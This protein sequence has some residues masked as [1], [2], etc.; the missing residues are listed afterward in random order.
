MHGE[1]KHGEPLTKY[2]KPGKVTKPGNLIRSLAVHVKGPSELVS[3]QNLGVVLRD[4]KKIEGTMPEFLRSYGK[5]TAEQVLSEGKLIVAKG[6]A[7]AGTGLIRI[8][9]GEIPPIRGCVDVANV[10]I[11]VGRLLGMQAK[12]VRVYN[13]SFAMLKGEEI[14]LFDISGTGFPKVLGKNSVVT[15]KEI[16]SD[17]KN[18]I[19]KYAAEGQ[20]YQGVDAH[21][22][23]LRG[24]E[25]FYSPTN[26][27][28]RVKTFADLE[29]F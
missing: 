22:V 19:G 29:L 12:F 11:A 15:L 4:L 18:L 6:K 9:D 2:H 27:K 21:H 26:K 3:L 16:T 28:A 10:A 13:H 5:R 17:V 8:Q 24:L 25:T 7:D 1:K 23:G 14:Y 20:V